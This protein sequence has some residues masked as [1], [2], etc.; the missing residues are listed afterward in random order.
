MTDSSSSTRNA[1]VRVEREQLF[2]K[3]QASFLQENNHKPTKIRWAKSSKDRQPKSIKIRKPT[4]G[5]DYPT[6]LLNEGQ[7]TGSPVGW[8]TR[9]T[10]LSTDCSADGNGPGLGCVSK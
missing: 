5:E 8:G 6:K 2:Y 10:S 1:K 3:R 9:S 4:E 7:S